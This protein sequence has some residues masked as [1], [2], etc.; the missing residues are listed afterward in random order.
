LIAAL[1]RQ[2]ISFLFVGSHDECD[3]WIKNNAGF[4]ALADNKTAG[5]LHVRNKTDEEKP[6]CPMQ[7][8]EDELEADDYDSMILRDLTDRDL[9]EIFSGIC[10][11]RA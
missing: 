6:A 5:V 8:D 11:K 9:R 2:E 4:E 1:G 7:E 10:G 3:H